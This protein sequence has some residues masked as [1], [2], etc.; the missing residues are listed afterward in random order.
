MLGGTARCGENGRR[1][2]PHAGIP[3]SSASLRPTVLAPVAQRGAIRELAGLLMATPPACR[4]RLLFC[5]GVVSRLPTSHS[6]LLA[7]VAGPLGLLSHLLTKVCVCVGGA[8]G[9]VVCVVRVVCVVCM[10]MCGGL[11]VC[12]AK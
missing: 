6:V 10:G 9:D 3:H 11:K 8:R 12:V 5:A 2:V 7:A 1:S 4:T